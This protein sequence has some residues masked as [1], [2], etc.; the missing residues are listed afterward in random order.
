MVLQLKRNLSSPAQAVV[1][2]SEVTGNDL[3]G[4][5][6]ALLQVL[7]NVWLGNV[8]C[9]GRVFR[10]LLPITSSLMQLLRLQANILLFIKKRNKNT[11]KE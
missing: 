6:S 8:L 11:L 3:A 10:L 4:Q 9:G 2:L 7:C 5:V 1:F